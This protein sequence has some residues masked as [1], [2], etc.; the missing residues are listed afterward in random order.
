M[1]VL[2]ALTLC[3]VHSHEASLSRNVLSSQYLF[4]TPVT[5]LFAFGLYNVDCVDE[6]KT[7]R[8]VDYK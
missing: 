5:M 4:M 1:I 3:A 8:T 2:R 7:L 6:L